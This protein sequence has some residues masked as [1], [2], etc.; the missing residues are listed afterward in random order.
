LGFVVEKVASV[1]FSPS[2]SVSPAIH[3][4]KLSI[5]TIARGRYNR[6]VS[7]RRAEWTLFGLHPP[8]SKLKKKL[9]N[10]Q[11]KL[12]MT[13]FCGM[14]QCSWQHVTDVSEEFV[15]YIFMVEKHVKK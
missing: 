3:S 14:T 7:G 8:L 13:V 10:K 9:K 15:A 2:T 6:P 1:S 5:L 4:T 11:M 12:K